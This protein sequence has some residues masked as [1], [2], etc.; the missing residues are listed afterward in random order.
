MLPVV[1]YGRE[2]LSLT[3]RDEYR[4]GHLRTRWWGEYLD[5]RQRKWQEA[6]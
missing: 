6:G 1:L 5:L 3:L 2:T 4:L